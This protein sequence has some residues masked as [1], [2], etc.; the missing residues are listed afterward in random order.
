MG[1]KN[2]VMKAARSGLGGT[3]VSLGLRLGFPLLPAKVKVK[4]KDFVLFCHPQPIATFHD[5]AV[6]RKRIPNLE[7]F[8]D[9]EKGWAA[10]A[11][12]LRENADFSQV[13]LCCNLGCRQDVGQVHFHLLPKDALREKPGEETETEPIAGWE[14]GFSSRGCLYLAH[15]SL[16][17][18]AYL[19]QAVAQGKR[20]Y[21][22]GFS[23]IWR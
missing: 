17:D 21:P 4:T 19:R 2:V 12:F 13:S 7:A 20:R 9:R 6:P 10:F 15:Q 18:A 11:A 16:E 5:L 3:L 1:V 22:K 14:T 8:L 23:M